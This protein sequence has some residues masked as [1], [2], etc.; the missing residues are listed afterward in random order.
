MKTLAAKATEK[1]ELKISRK[2]RTVIGS[3]QPKEKLE[4]KERKL[5]VSNINYRKNMLVSKFVFW[6]L[7][8]VIPS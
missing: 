3:F 7:K 6:Y 4:N 2:I 5:G 1:I 8:E